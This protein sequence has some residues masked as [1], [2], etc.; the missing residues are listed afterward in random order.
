MK[1]QVERHRRGRRKPEVDYVEA[2]AP[3]KRPE[4]PR[5]ARGPW[6]NQGPPALDVGAASNLH[7]PWRINRGN[8]GGG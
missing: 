3:R 8:D 2:R 1:V 6:G 4:A 5:T 7:L